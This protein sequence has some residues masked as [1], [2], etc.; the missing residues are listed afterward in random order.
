MAQM[1]L[2]AARINKG[3]TQINA[4]KQIGVAVSTLK[5]WENGKHFPK[6]PQIMAICEVYD[7][8]YDD[9]FFG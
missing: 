5:N 4:A 3:L 1:T 7:L 8:S 6:Q 2:K 9:I